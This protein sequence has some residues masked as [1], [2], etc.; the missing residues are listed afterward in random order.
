[1]ACKGYIP[2]KFTLNEQQVLI[3][4]HNTLR[5]IVANGDEKRG[6]PGPQPTAANMRAMEWNDELMMVAERWA[7]QCI[8]AN[9]I[10]RDL[11]LFVKKNP[12]PRTIFVVPERFPVGQNIALGNLANSNE[13]EF[14]KSWY[15][16]VEYFNSSE[17]E[18][19]TL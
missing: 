19:F 9:D 5:N 17:I 14:I 13:L 16:Q 6:N 18:R 2:V 3:D 15:D 10:C 8:Y 12:Y 11:G 1:M 7:A 4:A